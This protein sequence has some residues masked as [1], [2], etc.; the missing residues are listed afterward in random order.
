MPVLLL[1]TIVTVFVGVDDNVRKAS[2][3]F[4]Y[5]GYKVL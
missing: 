4:G 2:C 5:K 3:C 1:R